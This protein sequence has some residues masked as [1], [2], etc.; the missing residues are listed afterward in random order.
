MVGCYPVGRGD[1]CRFHDFCAASGTAQ[2]QASGAH[3][4]QLGQTPARERLVIVGWVSDGAKVR[5]AELAGFPLADVKVGCSTPSSTSRAG[6]ACSSPSRRRSGSACP[7][8]D[9]MGCDPASDPKGGVQ[10]EVEFVRLVGQPA[11]GRTWAITSW[12]WSSRKG[13]SCAWKLSPRTSSRWRSWATLRSTVCSSTTS[14]E[15]NLDFRT[16]HPIQGCQLL[17]CARRVCARCDPYLV[18]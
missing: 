5:I 3:A 6:A 14:F 16:A 4:L 9:W 15:Q 2:A 10:G 1:L 17:G 11:A 12:R 8:A 13:E 18:R 7:G